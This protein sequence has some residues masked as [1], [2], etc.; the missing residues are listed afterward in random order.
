MACARRYGNFASRKSPLESWFRRL[1]ETLPVAWCGS[2]KL[3]VLRLRQRGCAYTLCALT[4]V[5]LG[6]ETVW[7]LAIP[8]ED[9]GRILVE[10][11]HVLQGPVKV[12]RSDELI[13]AV[14]VSLRATL[15]PV[16]SA[17]REILE[18]LR[19]AGPDKVTVDFGLKLTAETG[20][21]IVKAAGEANFN[22]SLQWTKSQ[23]APS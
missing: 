16:V 12:A 2:P 6:G 20:A 7:L 3:S 19:E 22:V 8:L 23:D 17:S 4:L 11:D 15:D 1:D 18:R 21:V 5:D 9:G 10:S 14:S 13:T